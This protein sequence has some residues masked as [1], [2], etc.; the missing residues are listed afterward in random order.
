V[1]VLDSLPD[2]VTLVSTSRTNIGTLPGELKFDLGNLALG[3]TTTVTV[4]VQ[5]DAN[6]VGTLLNTTHVFANETEF[7]YTNNDD[8]EPTL[9]QADPGSLEGFVYNDKNNNGIKEAT[10]KPLAG[11]TIAL[12]GNELSSGAFISRTTT[13]DALGHYIFTGLMPGSY[14]VFEPTQPLKYKDGLDSLGVTVNAAGV[15]QAP[16]GFVAPDSQA[17]DDR[18][19]D[20]FEGIAMQSGFEA[21]DY[22]FGELAVTTNKRDFVRPLTYR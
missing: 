22:N 11:V 7:D 13:T 17:D 1:T 2:H 16:N 5:V 4:T 3:A 12:T 15:Q 20:A 14:M 8:E 18:D 19:S 9:V 21:K 6:F 10:E